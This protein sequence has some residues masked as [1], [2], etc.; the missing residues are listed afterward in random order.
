MIKKLYFILTITLVFGYAF[1]Q[2]LD[3]IVLNKIAIYKN[4]AQKYEDKTILLSKPIS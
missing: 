3:S 4:E 2:S 1:G